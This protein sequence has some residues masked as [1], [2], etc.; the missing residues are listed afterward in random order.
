MGTTN[1]NRRILFLVPNLTCHGAAKQ[2]TLLACALPRHEFE[3]CVG[4]VGE[5]GVFSETLR[6]A[7]I[8]VH[9]LGGRRN[10][11]RPM[12]GL[13][14]LTREFSPHLVKAW[15]STIG[16]AAWAGI[17][18]YRRPSWNLIAVDPPSPTIW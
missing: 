14:R 13:K 17:G 5:D 7:G 3:I 1:S 10:W 2:A 12:I 16:R 9:I 15:G 4:V 18:A 8:T 6:Q 11:L